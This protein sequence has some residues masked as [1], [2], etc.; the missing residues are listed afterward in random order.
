MLESLVT[1]RREDLRRID[2]SADQLDDDAFRYCGGVN[3]GV[4]SCI[5]PPECCGVAFDWPIIVSGMTLAQQYAFFSGYTD[6]MELVRDPAA[7][8]ALMARLYPTAFMR[9]IL[10]KYREELRMGAQ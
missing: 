7:W 1:R 10:R 2:A 4:L 5:E 3:L 6:S 9:A 8:I